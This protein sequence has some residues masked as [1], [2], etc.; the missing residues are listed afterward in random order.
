MK[1]LIRHYRDNDWLTVS[2]I[3]DL[4]RPIELA[5]SC[6]S[7][8]FV[9]LAEDQADLLQF[10]EC[11][12]LVA[13]LDERVVGFIGTSE[14]EI[15]WL[16]VDPAETRKGVGRLLLRKAVASIKGPASVH[17]LDGNSRALN[18]YQSE[19]FVIVNSFRSRNNGY[20]C[21]VLE[22]SLGR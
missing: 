16:Y 1:P 21:T 2:M 15:G 10:Q 13:C 8:A 14:N 22:L 4:A 7:R 18:L 6:D 19:G 5:G 11:R 20:P 12:K 9:P 3:H 17:V